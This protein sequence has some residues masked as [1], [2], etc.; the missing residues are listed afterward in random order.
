MLEILVR[1]KAL[2]QKEFRQLFRD[3]SNLLLGIGLPIILIFIF[4]Y[5]ISFDITGVKVADR[6]SVV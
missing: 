6:K 5:G 3:K 4:G 2:T 1:L